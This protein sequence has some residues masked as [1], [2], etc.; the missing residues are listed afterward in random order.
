MVH[1]TPD[2]IR[3]KCHEIVH[4]FDRPCSVQPPQLDNSLTKYNIA[5][6]FEKGYLPFQNSVSQLNMSFGSTL[7]VRFVSFI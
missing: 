1:L 3:K 4:T 5:H 2:E 6:L 7:I